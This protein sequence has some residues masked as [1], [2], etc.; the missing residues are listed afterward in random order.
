T[1]PTNRAVEIADK[2][3]VTVVGFVRGSRFNVYTH[4]ERIT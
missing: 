2:S 4:P 1:A 3:G